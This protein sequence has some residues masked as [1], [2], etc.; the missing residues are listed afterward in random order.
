MTAT[1]VG[2]FTLGECLPLALGAQVSLEAQLPE[3]QA[4]VTGALEAQAA[5]TLSPPTLSGNLEA[6]LGL[7]AQL[8]AAIALGMPSAGIDLTVM[9]AI[10]ADL[11]A[12]LGA[13]QAQLS[14]FSCLGAPGVY[15]VSQSG[16]LG[17]LGTDIGGV[18]TAIGPGASACNAVALV[19]TTPEAWAAV[20]VAIRTG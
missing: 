10:V 11:Q 13:L 3:L 15:L 14:L 9:A 8:E 6:A 1:L 16:T 20:S 2:S 7:V 4:K 12:S 18:A 17:E 5:I 19:C